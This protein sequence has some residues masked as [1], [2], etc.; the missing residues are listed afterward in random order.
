M[1]EELKALIGSLGP[2]AKHAAVCYSDQIRTFAERQ[3]LLLQEV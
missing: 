1:S 2:E 3:A